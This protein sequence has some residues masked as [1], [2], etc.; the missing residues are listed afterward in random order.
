MKKFFLCLSAAVVNLIFFAAL[1]YA[2]SILSAGTALEG[3]ALDKKNKNFPVLIKIENIEETT[4]NFTGEIT[5][6]S[7]NSIHRIAG[8][9]HEH[10]ITFKE[11]SHIK[12][13]GA[14]LNCEYAMVIDGKSMEGR[15]VE[16]ERDRGTIQLQIK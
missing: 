13:G 8:R 14:H 6:P 11:V 5:W 12:R 10:T 16:P 3:F 1:A 15:W 2:Q 4:G 7:L 9:I